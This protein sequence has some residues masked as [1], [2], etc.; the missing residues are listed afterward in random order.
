MQRENFH[1]IFLETLFVKTFKYRKFH[2]PRNK[3]VTLLPAG[4]LRGSKMTPE[5]NFNLNRILIVRILSRTFLFNLALNFSV[6]VSHSKNIL[7][8]P[9]DNIFHSKLQHKRILC[10]ISRKMCPMEKRIRV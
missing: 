9:A 5:F 7:A 3:N 4:I 10:S 6:R 2:F 1:E 8:V